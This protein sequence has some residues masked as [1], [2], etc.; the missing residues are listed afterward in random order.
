MLASAL[1]QFGGLDLQSRITSAAAVTLVLFG[2]VP[3]VV[4]RVRRIRVATTFR[5]HGAP[6]LSFVSAVL[7]GLVT[8]PLAH[9]LLAWGAKFGVGGITVDR[10]SAVKEYMETLRTISPTVILLCLAVMPALCEEFFFRGFLF[11][12]LRRSTTARGVVV[13]SALLFGAF[14]TFSGNVLTPERFL[15]STFLGLVLGWVCWRTGSILP[16]ILLHAVH[17]GLLLM[18]GFYMNELQARFP[19][20]GIES[21][22]GLRQH[23]QSRSPAL[24]RIPAPR[25]TQASRSTSVIRHS[26]KVPST[27][28]TVAVT[29]TG[30]C[31]SSC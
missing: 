12:A 5:V 14:H 26:S 23:A 10:L 6:L 2:V 16:G 19:F 15:P 3:L 24:A 9:Q 21:T 25:R 29:P 22:A 7:L 30:L 1:T 31:G 20:L 8:W 18:A 4:S 13:L 17:N 27:S 28:C 11:T